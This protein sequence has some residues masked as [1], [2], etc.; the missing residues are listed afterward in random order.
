MRIRLKDS[1]HGTII[2]M[3]AVCCVALFGFVALAIDLGMLMVARGECQ[4]AADAAALAGARYLDNR[5]PADIGPEA[6]DNRRAEAIANARSVAASNQFLN[7]QFTDAR[8]R[9]ARAGLYDFEPATQRFGIQFPNFKPSGKSWTAIEVVVDGEQPAYFANVLGISTLPTAARAVAAHRPRDIALVLDFSGSMQ[10][11][12]TTHWEPGTAGSNDL[13]LG[14]LNP[15]PDYPRF[16]HYARYTQ[17]QVLNPTKSLTTSPVPSARPN[18]LRMTGPFIGAT[19]EVFAPN[20]HTIE[21]PNGPP[22]IRDFLFSPTGH[23]PSSEVLLNAFHRWNPPILA[24][25]NS[26]TYRPPTYDWTGYSA[27]DTSNTR[28]PV[29]APPSFAEQSDEHATYAGDRHARIGGNG[30]PARHA[31]DL[32]QASIGPRIIPPTRPSLANSNRTEGGTQWTNYRDDGWERHG[33]DLDI[34]TYRAN[35][36]QYTPLRGELFLGY[37]MGPGYWGKT[38][39]LWPPDPRWGGVSEPVRPDLPLATNP[40]KDVNGNWIADW[41]R[42]FF[43]RGNSAE[44]GNPASYLY[45]D[46]QTDNDPNSAGVQNINQ[47][48]LRSVPGHVLRDAATGAARN[49]RLNYRAIL[50]WIKSGPQVFPPN[51]RAGRILYY[52]SIPDHVDNSATDPDQRFWRNYIDFV[53]GYTGN[54]TAYD[55]RYS[56]AGVEYLPWPEGDSITVGA[57]TPFDPDGDGPWPPNPLPY[58]NYTDNPNRPRMHF[59]FGPATMLAFLSTR[60]PTKNWLPGNSHEAQ[61][62]Q[63]KV[64]VQSA[65]EDIRNNHP[66]DHVGIIAFAYPHYSTPR[67]SVGQDWAALRNSL[68]FPKSILQELT[69]NPSLEVRPFNTGFGSA[70]LGNLPNAWGQTDPNTG[71]ALAFN[72]LR[73]PTAGGTGRPGAAKIVVFETDGVPNAFLNFNYSGSGSTSSYTFDGTGGVRSNGDPDVIQKAL[74]IAAQMTSDIALGGHSLPNAPARIYPI[75]F[76]DLFS[77]PSPF[78]STALQFLSSL[79]YHGRTAEQPTDP[80]PAVQIITGPSQ[81][82]IDNLRQAFERIMQSGVQI[83]L[84][85]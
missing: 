1:R 71:L 60:T 85:E 20:N 28:G 84:I 34:P 35:A 9:T 25:G 74:D 44:T 26:A 23:V 53:L 29:P 33:Y 52:A 42:R 13:V 70:L 69:N 18:P 80:L 49:Y 14:L 3:L 31:A 75:A 10:F 30:G 11:S 68:F 72:A 17:Y 22:L 39:F 7:A 37:S 5:F 57:T 40:A 58:L 83:T 6:Y 19:G 82:R 64:G 16:G 36:F 2:P 48:L 54:N 63:L 27:H 78:K 21:T 45:F 76:G 73:G 59:W 24:P 4:N 67:V 79:A 56:L 46:P 61:N 38:F 8:I 77:S 41:R 15:D 55:A 50:A 32:L 65:L 47:A 51:L 43:L 62:W 12:S 81:T 66:N